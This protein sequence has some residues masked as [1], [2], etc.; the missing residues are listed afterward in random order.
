M[1]SVFTIPP[2]PRFL[3]LPD[4]RALA[5][6]AVG[7]PGAPPI[8]HFH[9]I[10]SSRLEV[11]WEAASCGSLGYRVICPDRPGIGLSDHLPGRSLL[12]WPADAAGA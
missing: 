10:P 5:Y 3:R 2:Q 7:P 12:D 4:G 1:A 8:M 6:E 11:F 9:S